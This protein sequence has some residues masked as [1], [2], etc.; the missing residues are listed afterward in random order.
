[1]AIRDFIVRQ[2]QYILKQSMQ[3]FAEI[4]E[5]EIPES[6]LTRVRELLLQTCKL[7]FEVNIPDNYT[8]NSTLTA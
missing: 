4:G 1:M 2:V 5:R 7:G 8:R 6:V 3:A